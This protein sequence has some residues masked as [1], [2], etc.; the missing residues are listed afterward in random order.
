MV[1][2]LFQ[3]DVVSWGELS[4]WSIPTMSAHM[5]VS[6]HI[7]LLGDRQ[8]A[9]GQTHD[10]FECLPPLIQEGAQFL[11]GRVCSQLHQGLC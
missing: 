6:F 5:P 2:L 10:S 9:H 4:F 3:Q 8:V 11:V 7:P 1:L